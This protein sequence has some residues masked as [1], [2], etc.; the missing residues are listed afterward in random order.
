MTHR[1]L[2]L[3]K[4]ALFVFTLIGLT[5]RT[6][7]ADGRNPVEGI[8]F[9]RVNGP[10]PA[11]RYYKIRRGINL[12][13]PKFAEQ[14]GVT[15]DAIRDDNP[16]STIAMCRLSGSGLKMDLANPFSNRVWETC[17]DVS[18]HYVYVIPDS[19]I[20][21][22]GFF[23][24][25]YNERSEIGLRLVECKNDAAC[26]ST[27]LARLGLTAQVVSVAADGSPAPPVDVPALQAANACL[28]SRDCLM[29]KLEATGWNAPDPTLPLQLAAAA[30][31][32]LRAE[33]LK[34]GFAA[35][36]IC[37]AALLF[38]ANL[39]WTRAWNRRSHERDDAIRRSD[40]L[41]VARGLLEAELFLARSDHDKTR[42]ELMTARSQ[43]QSFVDRFL[44]IS[45]RVRALAEHTHVALKGDVEQM[46]GDIRDAYDAR[47]SERDEMQ[48]RAKDVSLKLGSLRKQLAECSASVKECLTGHTALTSFEFEHESPLAEDASRE[49][50]RLAAALNASWARFEERLDAIGLSGL[51]QSDLFQEALLATAEAA[52]KSALVDHTVSQR[53]V[54]LSAAEGRHAALAMQLRDFDQQLK[55]HQLKAKS[56]EALQA[57]IDQKLLTL[58]DFEDRIR[59]MVS[60]FLS[61]IGY[62]DVQTFDVMTWEQVRTLCGDMLDLYDA[63][64]KEIAG[65]Q[66]ERDEA[67][68]QLITAEDAAREAHEHNAALDREHQAL[69]RSFTELQA[70][71]NETEERRGAAMAQISR[72][73]QRLSELEGQA[74][75]EPSFEA[76]S[77]DK[78]R[79]TPTTSPIVLASTLVSQIEHLAASSRPLHLDQRTAF[80]FANLLRLRVST[81]YVDLRYGERPGAVKPDA[82]DEAVLFEKQFAHALVRDIPEMLRSFKRT[83]PGIPVPPLPST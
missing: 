26:V 35:S 41:D 43:G 20:E 69:T 82:S 38:A 65:V 39:G 66:H 24:P 13:T 36:T 29:H 68:E 1:F 34:S 80:A 27:Q 71:A 63:C 75:R 70:F 44:S 8:D 49:R 40:Q 83:L 67:Y 55:Q 37:L 21:L 17:K 9:T 14:L 18:Q 2:S 52:V 51:T 3:I 32:G 58:K 74:A 4:L 7:L 25:D 23:R 15:M 79:W 48:A 62:G 76:R 45:K 64:Q 72:L 10:H 47:V 33:R 28:G 46:L 54:A 53:E 57:V 77:S 61:F 73:E 78:R 6:A 22:K 59:P 16:K 42:T 5:A 11:S 19:V 31:F 12:N 81:S 50:E 60:R 30:S 56:L